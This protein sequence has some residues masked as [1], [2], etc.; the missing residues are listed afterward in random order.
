MIAVLTNHKHND[1]PHTCNAIVQYAVIVTNGSCLK[2][3]L[4]FMVSPLLFV[5]MGARSATSGLKAFPF[6]PYLR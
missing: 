5:N 6:L 3:F 1:I 2:N 4:I